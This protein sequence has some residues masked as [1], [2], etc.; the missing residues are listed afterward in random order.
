MNYKTAT[1]ATKK[2]IISNESTVASQQFRKEYLKKIEVEEFQRR[3]NV[4]M[5]EIVNRFIAYKKEELKLEN[6]EDE[7]IEKIIEDMISNENDEFYDYSSDEDDDS[8][9]SDEDS[10]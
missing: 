4:Q 5:N 9:Y 10:F 1:T 3:A 2:C 7:E 6:H 8:I